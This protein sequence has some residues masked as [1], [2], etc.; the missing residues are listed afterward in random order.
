VPSPFE[1]DED[2]CEYVWIQHFLDQPQ[3]FWKPVLEMATLEPKRGREF[4]P[5][6]HPVAQEPI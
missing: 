4:L 2:D 3:T 6:N 5:R 1:D